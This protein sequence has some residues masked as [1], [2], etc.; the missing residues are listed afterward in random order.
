[1]TVRGQVSLATTVKKAE[2]ANRA[3]ATRSL[4]TGGPEF[5]TRS[6]NDRVGIRLQ[7]VAANSSP[8]P[9]IGAP[10]IAQHSALLRRNKSCLGRS[11][12]LSHPLDESGVGLPPLSHRHLIRLSARRYGSPQRREERRGFLAGDL[13]VLPVSAVSPADRLAN[14]ARILS[15]PVTT[16]PFEQ[17]EAAAWPPSTAATPSNTVNRMGW[18]WPSPVFSPS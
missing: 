5:P 3:G 13:G 2:R 8:F 6:L 18:P 9:L 10:S 12:N 4:P 7:Q 1:M 17:H 14:V 16:M 15:N 11:W